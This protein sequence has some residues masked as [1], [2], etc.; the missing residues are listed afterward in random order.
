MAHFAKL[1]Q[2]NTVTN[3]IVVS[4]DAILNLPFPQSEPIGQAFC[5]SLFKDG[6]VWKQTSY[7]S[8]FR[9]HY[10]GLGYSYN[11]ALDAFIPPQDFP[12]WVLDGET[13]WW[14][15][16]VPYPADGAEYMWDEPSLS[17]VAAALAA[18]VESLPVE[19]PVI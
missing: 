2:N 5:E 12:S 8:N 9:K 11:E 18:P 10:A 14:V 13:F 19:K 7:N 16:P 6:A 1:D 17:W 4:N 3:V 15:P